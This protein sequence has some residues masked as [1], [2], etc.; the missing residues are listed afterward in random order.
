MQ[1]EIY[2][3]SNKPHSEKEN[4]S[5]S[6]ILLYTEKLKGNDPH[7]IVV[8]HIKSVKFTQPVIHEVNFGEE[9]FK[10]NFFLISNTKDSI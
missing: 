7:N 4:E 10:G 3:L 2:T 9:L 6:D 5:I 1:I 8:Y